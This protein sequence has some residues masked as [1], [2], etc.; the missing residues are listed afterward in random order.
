M[1]GI[2]YTRSFTSGFAVLS[3]LGCYI[4]QYIYYVYISY[5]IGASPSEPHIDGVAGCKLYVCMYG[6]I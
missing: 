4:K 3:K 6:C 1:H 2:S 5:I